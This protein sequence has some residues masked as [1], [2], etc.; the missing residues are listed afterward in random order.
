[1]AR[2]VQSGSGAASTAIRAGTGEL[3]LE[4]AAAGGEPA[5]RESGRTWSWVAWGVGE[6]EGGREDDTQIPGAVRLS[7]GAGPQPGRLRW[8]G[9]GLGLGL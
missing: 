9:G 4:W 8:R 2:G 6:R 1:M 5:G 7:R 3:R